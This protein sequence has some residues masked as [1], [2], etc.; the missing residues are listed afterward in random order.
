MMGTGP[1]I[2]TR[3]TITTNSAG[4]CMG[5]SLI[6]ITGQLEAA[7]WGDWVRE[8]VLSPLTYTRA[9]ERAGGAPVVL[10]PVP[11]DNV[12]RLVDSLDGLGLTGGTDI[13]PAL[14]Q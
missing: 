11:S 1:L 9:V 6:G 8:A 7:H 14:Y 5:R 2:A 4:G 10:P 12:D 3:R 13:S